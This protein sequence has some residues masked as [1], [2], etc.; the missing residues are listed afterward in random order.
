VIIW[1]LAG[2]LEGAVSRVSIPLLLGLG[3]GGVAGLA[4]G[5]K[6]RNLGSL[7]TNIFFPLTL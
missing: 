3:D 4:E 6:A 2:G 1:S 5:E 7:I